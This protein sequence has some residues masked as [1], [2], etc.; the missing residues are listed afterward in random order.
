MH[1]NSTNETLRSERVHQMKKKRKQ[2]VGAVYQ[3][4][5]ST[6]GE[7][8]TKKLIDQCRLNILRYIVISPC[9]VFLSF[10]LQKRGENISLQITFFHRVIRDSSFKKL[11]VYLEIY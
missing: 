3:D 7:R 9:L 11:Q 5:L 10:P 6:P 8:T 2:K 1:S 4:A